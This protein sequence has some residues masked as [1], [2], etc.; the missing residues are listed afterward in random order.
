MILYRRT[1]T[2]SGLIAGENQITV[3][4][5]R[6]RREIMFRRATF[7]PSTSSISEI[8]LEVNNEI[9]SEGAIGAVEYLQQI[10]DGRNAKVPQ[11]GYEVY[12]RAYR[13]RLGND[14]PMSGVQ[15]FRFLVTA[16][17]ALDATIIYETVGQLQ[18]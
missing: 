14:L 7:I 2:Q 1:F 18:G 9:V 4:P 12:D 6:S 3:L 17:G 10:G 15:D 16:A 11:S 8:K 13:G 5:Y